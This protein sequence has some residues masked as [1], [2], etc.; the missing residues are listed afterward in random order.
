MNKSGVAGYQQLLDNLF[1]Q[2]SKL[3]HDMELQA[4]WARYLCV[5][6]SGFLEVAI[7]AIYG[8][9]AQNKAAPYVSNFVQ[10]KLREFQNPNMTKIVALAKSFNP[11]WAEELTT[12]TEGELKDAIDSIVANRHLIAHGEQPGI[13]YARVLSYYQRAIKVIAIINNQCGN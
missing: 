7:Q 3:S 6:I 8:N 12:R 10:G 13:T 4:H 9:Y 1:T 5:L 2:V 11:V